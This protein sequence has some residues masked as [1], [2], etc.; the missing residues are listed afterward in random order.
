MRA[1]CRCTSVLTVG[2]AL[3]AG[4]SDA[5]A[6]Q[7]SGGA[8]GEVGSGGARGTGGVVGTGGAGAVGGTGGLDGSV[9]PC[10]GPA[11]ADFP[12]G[13]AAGDV[14]QSSAVLWTRAS[15]GEKVRFEYGT[16]PDFQA[17][18]GCVDVDLSIENGDTIPSKATITGLLAGTQYHYRACSGSCASAS[19]EECGVPGSFRTPHASGRKGL[20]FGVSSCFEGRMRPF[21]SIRNVPARNLDFFVA[22]GD[23]AYADHHDACGPPAEDLDDFR[24]KHGLA[25]EQWKSPDDNMFAQARASTAF[26][27]SID[28]HEVDNDFAGGEGCD[29]DCYNDTDLFEHGLQAFEE[30]N[31]TAEETYGQTGDPR[32]AGERKLYRYRTFGKD[33]ALLMLDARSFR[34]GPE[35]G[36]QVC[37][38][39]DVLDESPACDYIELEKESYQTTVTMLGSAQLQELLDD[40]RDAEDRGI[41]WK[42]ILVPE[43]IQNLGPVAAPD[44]FE[45]YAYERAVILD[46]IENNCIG[47]VVF[48]SGDIHGTI[49]NN[50]VYRPFF[51]GTPADFVTTL[52]KY[53]SSWDIST[54][55]GAYDRPYGTLVSPAREWLCAGVGVNNIIDGLCGCDRGAYDA[56]T[57]EGKAGAVEDFMDC[58]LGLLN[59][60]K[61]GLSTKPQLLLVPPYDPRLESI[62]NAGLP[63]EL[64][65]GRYVAT[66]SFGWTEF[67]I[68][69]VTQKLE[70]TTYGVD[71]YELPDS[72]AGYSEEEAAH[73]RERVPRIMS[74]FEVEPRCGCQQLACVGD[75][76]CGNGCICDLIGCVLKNSVP[77]G[78]L[79]ADADACASGVCNGICVSPNSVPLGSPCVADAACLRGRCGILGNE[80]VGICQAECGDGICDAG[81]PEEECGKDNTGVSCIA[82]CGRCPN[83][84]LCVVD[85]TCASGRCSTRCAPCLRSGATCARDGSCCSGTCRI[86]FPQGPNCD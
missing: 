85:A 8:G 81:R 51:G 77:N 6:P 10:E 83:G 68:D 61:T 46:F 32:T 57:T 14:D 36:Q 22:L 16:D 5:A 74:Q 38:Y 33:A 53:S 26:F 43:P 23:V 67:N 79:C 15:C 84:H 70:V 64:L 29:G 62:R 37:D 60:P 2:L 24:C 56:L 86:E 40:L 3:L 55:P 41:I 44:R 45:G 13:V 42:F 39:L 18:D 75:G 54:G 80:P 48:I 49:A 59:Y 31:P 12:N 17:S 9:G 7:G 66:S 52:R 65:S 11:S 21:V 25:Y 1:H 71:P 78:E 58:V 73:F 27:A 20:R 4:C 63:E 34:D 82:D 69:A 35:A 76:A 47:N 50:L 19:A 72:N 30:Y 28:D